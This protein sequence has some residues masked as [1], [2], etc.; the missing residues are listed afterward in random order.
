M[1]SRIILSAVSFTLQIPAFCNKAIKKHA[2]FYSQMNASKFWRI[3]RYWM[4][5]NFDYCISA[6][7]MCPDVIRYIF[8]NLEKGS[9]FQAIALKRII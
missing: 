7:A 9:S 2:R 6:R 5:E 8:S 4:I 1:T 3:N